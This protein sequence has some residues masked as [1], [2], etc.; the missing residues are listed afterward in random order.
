MNR[1][2]LA[3]GDIPAEQGNGGAWRLRRSWCGMRLAGQWA[4]AQATAITGEFPAPLLPALSMPSALAATLFSG[5]QPP[6]Y[7]KWGRWRAYPIRRES[8]GYSD[9]SVGTAASAFLGVA[10]GRNGRGCRSDDMPDFECNEAP[11][12]TAGTD[13]RRRR[14]RGITMDFTR[15][16]N[17]RPRFARTPQQPDERGPSSPS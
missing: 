8:A 11:Q 2:A 9:L 14:R 7:L 10:I 16:A 12:P 1:S 13:N 17:P 15:A 6:H 5:K 4:T 3:G